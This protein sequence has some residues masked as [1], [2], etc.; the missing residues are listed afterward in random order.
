VHTLHDINTLQVVGLAVSAG[1]RVLWSVGK[2]TV[3][4]WRTH[5]EHEQKLIC[6]HVSLSCFTI[7]L[8]LEHTQ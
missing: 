7:K 5:S 3:S 8:C 1:G 4:L 2:A 6:M